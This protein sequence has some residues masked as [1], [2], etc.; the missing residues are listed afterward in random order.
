MLASLLI[1]TL[2]AYVVDISVLDVI[3]VLLC[4]IEVIERRFVQ[5]L[6][7]LLQILVFVGLLKY[8]L[9]VLTALVQ[10]LR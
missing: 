1:C 5:R 2:L 10:N 6:L 8:G 3:L 9:L 4:G 7:V